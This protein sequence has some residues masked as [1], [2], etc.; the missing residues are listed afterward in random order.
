M[1]SLTMSLALLN[2]ASLA[3]TQATK[4]GKT[5]ASMSSSAQ[6][7]EAK[8][9]PALNNEFYHYTFIILASLIVSFGI[10][11]IWIESVKYVR[12]LTCLN[13]ETQ[14]YFAAPSHTFALIK[15]NILYAP[16]FSKRHNREFQ[17]SAAVN[18]GT[19]PTRFQFFILAGYFGT[20][21]AFCVASIQWNETYTTVCQ[22]L[23]NRTGVLAVVNMVSC[24]RRKTLNYLTDFRTGS[25][26]RHGST[27]QPPHQ[28]AE[29]VF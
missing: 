11:R 3:S 4:G 15:K 1:T 29:L 7:V 5:G 28:M 8:A 26:G 10:W 27:K 18:V 14:R 20:N 16:I 25:T 24:V 2:L 22:Q 23:R 21:V 19:L 13:N 17:I 6:E 12:T 9:A